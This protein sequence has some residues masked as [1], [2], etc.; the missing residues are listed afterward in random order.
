MANLF[1][2]NNMIQNKD[3][4]LAYSANVRISSLPV[5]CNFLFPKTIKCS[6]LLFLSLSVQSSSVLLDMPLQS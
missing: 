5:Q 6:M 2:R 4:D 3:V 1:C